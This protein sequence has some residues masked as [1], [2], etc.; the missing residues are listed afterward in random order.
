MKRVVSSSIV[1]LFIIAAVA[2]TFFYL[3]NFRLS[4][5]DPRSAIPPDAAFFI[6]ADLSEFPPETLIGPAYRKAFG[7]TPAFIQL[8][9]NIRWFDSLLTANDEF[10]AFAGGSKIVI[11]AQVTGAKSFDFLFIKS[12]NKKF[13][14]EAIDRLMTIVLDREQHLSMRKYDGITIR[15]VME[16]NKVV[17]AY[18]MVKGLFVAGKT[19]FLVE[20]GIR[21]ARSGTSNVDTFSL[22][23]DGNSGNTFNIYLN[24]KKLSGLLGTITDA[25]IDHKFSTI[26]AFSDWASA[27]IEFGEEAI[28]LNGSVLWTDS[29]TLTEC[30]NDQIPRETTI[31]EVLPARTAF[32]RNIATS[33]KVLFLRKLRTLYFNNNQKAR[34]QKLETE[35]SDAY[36]IRITETMDDL[37]GNEFA[38]IITEPSG[39]SYENSSFAVFSL[40]DPGKAI[41][42]L[43]KIRKAVNPPGAGEPQEYKSCSVGQIMISNLIPALYGDEFS[44]ISK[45]WYAVIG[46]HIV[47]A[48]QQATLRLLIDDIKSGYLL[49]KATSYKSVMENL[50]AKSTFIWYVKPASSIGIFRSSAND[51]WKMYTDKYRDAFTSVT[52]FCFSVNA[53]NGIHRFNAVASFKGGDIVSGMK[54]VLTIDTDTSVSVKPFIT[55]D[56][57]SGNKQIM[58][59]DESNSVY[60]CDNTGSILWKETVNGKIEGEIF[61]IDLFKNNLR[62]FL[63]NT[64]EHLYLLD[65]S[66]KPVGNYPI[67]LPAPASNGLAVYDFDGRKDP[68]I[69]IA[70]ENNQVYAYL[71]SGKPMPGWS[72]SALK[73]NVK[74]KIDHA[75]IQNKDYLLIS[76]EL[77][78]LQ[79]VTKF[80]EPGI[81]LTERF[82]VA[83]NA[84]IGNK[85]DGALVMTDRN[86]NIRI[87]NINGTVETIPLNAAGDDHG[88]AYADVD[89]DGNKDF[90]FTDEDEVTA[91]NTSLTMVFRQTFESKLTGDVAFH[92]NEDGS[93][94]ISVRSLESDQTWLLSSN[95]DLLPGSPVQGSSK[96]AF[97]KTGN[98]GKLNLLLGGRGNYFRVYGVE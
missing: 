82:V 3:Q 8:E 85:D 62:Q 4:G 88:F 6:V 83:H 48:N 84:L 33:D 86:G 12:L 50:P 19:S 96:P 68:R 20:D 98:E 53:G 71:P 45:S 95:G 73:G 63:F 75:K 80:G 59:Q 11:S 27:D 60:L 78:G 15:E 52:G 17:F 81:P 10:N 37:T 74:R 90:V 21:Q 58:F 43:Q 7:I 13:D 70:C 18:A 5:T 54:Q 29:L 97:G 30:I 69:Y 65:E 72:F 25:A 24:F 51:V 64:K 49:A 28:K 42:T 22:L 61:E 41:K 66:G 67:R 93:K 55:I 31:N 79:I 91:Y 44:K 9:N 38:L 1:T 40:T 76:D 2:V 94:I 39:S 23:E 14:D 57:K 16:K 47:F 34:L 87:V 46:N 35:T 56:P 92:Q 26:D 36:G 89:D 32:F 77:S